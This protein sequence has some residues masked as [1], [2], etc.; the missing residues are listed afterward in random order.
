MGRLLMNNQQESGKMSFLDKRELRLKNEHGKTLKI[1]FQWSLAIWSNAGRSGKA[2]S[3]RETMLLHL[4]GP[5]P[6]QGTSI[7][8]QYQTHTP[9]SGIKKKQKKPFRSLW[10]LIHTFCIIAIHHNKHNQLCIKDSL[11]VTLIFFFLISMNKQVQ[12]V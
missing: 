11:Y 8:T 7:K 10:I 9:Q 6:A 5:S 12:G 4:Q 2:L 3:C 1:C